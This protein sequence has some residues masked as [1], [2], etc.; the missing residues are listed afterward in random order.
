MSGAISF[1]YTY[2]EYENK[3]KHTNDLSPHSTINAKRKTG[4]FAYR[5]SIVRVPLYQDLNKSVVL[6]HAVK[7]KR[8]NN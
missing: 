5:Q 1:L 2:S 4:L 3:G 8:K 6:I 7:I